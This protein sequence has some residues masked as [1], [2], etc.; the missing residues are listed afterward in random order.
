MRDCAQII[1]E[2]SLSSLA[3]RVLLMFKAVVIYHAYQVPTEILE[4]LGSFH[5]KIRYLAL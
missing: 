2:L 5:L 1:T 4:K 3:S